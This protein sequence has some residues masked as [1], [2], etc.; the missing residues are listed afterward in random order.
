MFDSNYD[1]SQNWNRASLVFTYSEK[2]L[3]DKIV[4]GNL[5]QQ[6]SVL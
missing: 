4:Q 6:S 3:L 1:S 5:V 2:T